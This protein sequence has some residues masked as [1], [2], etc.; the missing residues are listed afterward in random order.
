MNL[1]IEKIKAFYVLFQTT[2]NEK[3]AG[4]EK[5]QKTKE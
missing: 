1:T 3:M 4:R 2:I 5:V